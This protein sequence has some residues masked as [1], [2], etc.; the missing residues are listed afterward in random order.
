VRKSGVADDKRLA[1]HLDRLRAAGPAPA[2]PTQLAG[3]LV[4]DGLLT[5]FQA[6]QLL[7]GKWRR[8]SIGKYKVLERLGAG[9]M[10]SV[11]LC[12][13]KLMRRRVAVKVLPTAKADDP[14]S[15]ERFYREA[16]AV[17]ALDHPNIVRA[18]DI[19]Q[20][21]Q[22]HFL[23]MEYV[24]GASLQEIVKKSGPMDVI[25]SCHYIAQSALGL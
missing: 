14:S 5:H 8:F 22:L 20:D 11:Y 23:V 17:A 2:D 12:E 7:Q 4:R 1:A 9:G 13:H 3:V 19:D 6:E 15:L 21:E 18:Y 25:R 16:R 10:G 24:D